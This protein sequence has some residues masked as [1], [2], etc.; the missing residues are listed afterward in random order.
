MLDDNDALVRALLLTNMM[1]SSL[2]G[3]CGLN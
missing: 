3:K 1:G 2:I